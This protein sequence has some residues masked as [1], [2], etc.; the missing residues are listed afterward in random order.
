M[1]V[2]PTESE[3]DQPS[4]SNFTPTLY[5]TLSLTRRINIFSTLLRDH[6]DLPTL[7]SSQPNPK[8][9]NFTVLAPLNSALQSL[10]Q[11]PWEDVDEYA[12]LGDRAYDGESGRDRA[13]GN[14]K[15]FVEGHVVPV[16]P[17]RVEEKVMTLRGGSQELWWEEKEAD[18]GR[19]E[20]KRVIM[21]G[22]I[23][24]EEVVSRVGNGE[25]WVLKGVLGV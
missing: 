12:A 8:N 23:E 13:K 4:S 2:L 7:L 18:D 10:S 20:K 1:P 6:P 25:I 21:P 9:T 24:V 16:S 15:R 22:E 11:K 17:W 14:L 3:S 19:E 5:D